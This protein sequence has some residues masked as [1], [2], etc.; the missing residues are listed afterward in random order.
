MNESGRKRTKT[1]EN[2]LNRM[3][4]VEK[5]RKR[6]KLNKNG[7]KQTKRTKSIEN[8]QERSKTDETDRIRRDEEKL[9]RKIMKD[10]RKIKNPQQL[11]NVEHLVGIDSR[12]QYLISALRLS[13]IVAVPEVSGSSKTAIVKAVYDKISAAGNDKF[14]PS[15][16]DGAA[17]IKKLISGQK[18]FFG[19]PMDMKF[20][21][22]IVQCAG[23]IPLVLK[24]TMVKHVGDVKKNSS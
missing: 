11:C 13:S 8:R 5:E 20:V 4:T 18:L 7:R 15:Q 1:G 9:I 6:S 17:K 2:G 14:V 23:G 16:N 22:E 10:V 3:K 21:D 12:A 24:E 19:D